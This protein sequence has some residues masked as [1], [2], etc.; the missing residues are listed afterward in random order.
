MASV[1]REG[2]KHP[3][4]ITC[5]VDAVKVALLEMMYD[6]SQR[7]V[8]KDDFFPKLER[9]LSQSFSTRY[10]EDSRLREGHRGVPINKQDVMDDLMTMLIDGWIEPAQFP[11]KCC[12]QVKRDIRETFFHAERFRLTQAGYDKVPEHIFP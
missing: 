8:H 4:M 2:G 10:V 11:C 6:E 12:E 7:G 3:L 9:Y 5:W 1:I